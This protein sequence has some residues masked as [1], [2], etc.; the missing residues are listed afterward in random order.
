MMNMGLAVTLLA[1]SALLGLLLAWQYLRDSPR[2]LWMV[3]FHLIL[4]VAAM[5]FVVLFM[6]GETAEGSLL[7]TLGNGA[8]LATALALFSGLVKPVLVR[9]AKGRL[10]MSMV[11]LHAGV[12]SLGLLLLLAWAAAR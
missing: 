11:A 7:R 4:G 5:K 10:A 1:A 9:E 12:G 3:G 8:V 2:K 6:L